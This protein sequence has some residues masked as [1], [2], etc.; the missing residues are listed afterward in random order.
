MRAALD[1]EIRVDRA[2][3]DEMIVSN[4]K[5][6][7][8]ELFQQ[9][10]FELSR[11]NLHDKDSRVLVDCYGEPITSCVL[12]EVEFSEPT[13]RPLRKGA[14]QKRFEE[15]FSRE[16]NRGRK[17]IPLKEFREQMALPNNRWQELIHSKGFEQK[18]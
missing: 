12:A 7:D 10:A 9:K 13:E 14:N 3:S 16:W 18:F 15:L 4:T 11:I 17:R 8:A 6:K 2:E 5:Q 1:T